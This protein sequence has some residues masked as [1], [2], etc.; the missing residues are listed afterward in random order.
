MALPLITQQIAKLESSLHF[1]RDGPSQNKHT[2]FVDDAEE[3]A[4][5]EPAAYFETAPELADRA[6]NRPRLSTLA[7]TTVAAPAPEDKKARAKV[8]TPLD[9]SG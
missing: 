8:S 9:H 3:V 4:N 7:K 5:F 6:Y 1:L 2:I